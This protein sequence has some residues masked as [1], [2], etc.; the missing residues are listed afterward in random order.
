MSARQDSDDV[1]WERSDE[2]W[3]EDMRRAQ[4]NSVGHKIEAFAGN[5]FGSPAT[6][7]D[8]IILGGFNAL[9]PVRIQ[10]RSDAVLVRCPLSHRPL[11]P[12]EQTLSEAATIMFL[13]QH[14][15]IPIPKLSNYGV[16]TDIGPFLV[17]Q[18]LGSRRDLC[19]VLAAPRES[20]DETPVLAADIPESKLLEVY[21]KLGSFLLQMA[22]FT[23]PR[24]GSL[25]ETSPGSFDVLT[26][27][28]TVNMATIVHQS[29]IPRSILPA[30]D[31]TY[32]TADAWYTALADLQL[33]TLLF[34]HNDMVESADDC[35]TKYVARQLFRRLAKQGRLS[36]FGFSDD[37]WSAQAKSLTV[38]G[39][40]P[41]PPSGPGDGAFRLW[42]DDFRPANILVADDGSDAIL[43]AVDW[44]F[45]YAAPAQ[46]VLNP[47][48]WLLLQ[49]PELWEDGLEDWAR[50]Y[51]GRVRTWLAAL[52]AAERD[53]PEGAFLLAGYM[54]QS[55]ETGRFWLDY[56]A[57]KSFAFDA[58][59]W[60][61]LDGM[62]FG[63]REE[64]LPR[65]ELWKTRVDLLGEEE[66]D[67]M[68]RMV[69]IKME[70]AKERVLVE[71]WDEEARERLASFLFD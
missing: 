62:F 28:M 20:F 44:E 43:G 37:R 33:A 19:D 14:T 24:I 3:D 5:M 2:V 31:T 1:A 51:D 18:D 55:W 64:G 40:L 57:R 67:A 50:V 59:Y 17:M 11:F 22:Q 12:E 35:R 30:K 56:A 6:V 25:V 29:N 26:R 23:F 21:H 53:M 47:P 8:P 65:E 52:E 41:A 16:D 42:A 39:A 46:F 70:E 61:Y 48:W 45:A 27:P 60:K 15:R 4:R 9:Y 54:R 36:S 7:V 13:S 68:E 49:V 34:Q 10:G 69:Q 71:W 32:P 66:R 58:I 63:E 38:T